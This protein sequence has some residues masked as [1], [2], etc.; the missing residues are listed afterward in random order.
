M[1][2]AH[3]SFGTRDVATTDY[4]RL[5][6][7]HELFSL[8]CPPKTALKSCALQNNSLHGRIKEP[9]H[10]APCFL[11]FV[12]GQVGLL[13][14]IFDGRLMTFE[15]SCADTCGGSVFKIAKLVGFVKYGADLFTHGFCLR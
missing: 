1:L 8:D 10:I 13:Q 6:M 11:G 4:L 15:Q 9:Y 14:K 12:H 7:D 3:K 5:V 2:P